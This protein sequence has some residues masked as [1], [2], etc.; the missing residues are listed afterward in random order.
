MLYRSEFIA[1]LAGV[2]IADANAMTVWF[3][4]HAAFFSNQTHTSPAIDPQVFVVDASA[5]AALGPQ[6]IEHVAGVRPLRLEEESVPVYTA[7]GAGLGFTGSKWLAAEGRAIVTPQ[8]VEVRL[9]RLIAFG[10]YS[11]FKSA[12]ESTT[13]A[14][15]DGEGKR[16]SL[17]ADAMGAATLTVTIPEVLTPRSAILLVY[18]SDGTDHTLQR[19]KIGYTAHHQLIAQ[20]T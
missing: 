17:K 13:F 1:G 15:L 19:G 16:N 12:Y 14:P 3:Q 8:I 4:T 6:S 7:D 5:A 10:I 18:H 9:G 11:L 20:L 2:T